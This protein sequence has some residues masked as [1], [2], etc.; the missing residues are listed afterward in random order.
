M[1]ME[2]DENVQPHPKP[3]PMCTTGPMLLY[4]A[5]DLEIAAQ[6]YARGQVGPCTPERTRSNEKLLCNLYGLATRTS[7][8][9]PTSLVVVSMYRTSV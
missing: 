1:E 6:T 8:S 2:M 5:C 4:V 3:A 7:L 9:R